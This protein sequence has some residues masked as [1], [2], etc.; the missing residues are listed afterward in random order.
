MGLAAV[1]AAAVTYSSTTAYPGSLVAVPVVGAG[2]VMAGGSAQPARGAEWLLHLRPFQLLGLVSYSLYLWH[3]P[4][5]IIAA[6]YYG[7]ASLGAGD[8][9]ALMLVALALAAGTYLVVENPVRRSRYLITRPLATGAMACCLVAA[10]LAVTT[11]GLR[12]SKP[13]AIAAVETA[14]SGST[15][16]T[17]SEAEVDAVRSDYPS[18]QSAPNTTIGNGDRL[19]LVGDST[20]CTLLPGLMAVGQDY[21]VKVFN[22]GVIGCGI[23]SGTIAPY[24]YANRNLVA[25]TKSCQSRARQAEDAAIRRGRPSIILWAS[26]EETSSIVADTGTG[27]TVLVVGTP[28]WDVVMRRRIEARVHQFVTTGAKVILVLEPPPLDSGNPSQ[29]TARDVN[30]SVMNELLRQVAAKNP[31][32]VGVVNLEELLCPS[33]PPCPGAVD[34]IAVRGDGIHYLPP[35]SVWVARWLVPQVLSAAHKLS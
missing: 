22:G 24:Y 19:L 28:R 21:G 4:I 17:P 14:A 2:L 9:A 5:L 20:A 32:H 16:P 31:G 30:Y 29:P 3:W 8:N 33:G 12:H 6:E 15:C 13:G 11:F 18:G 34:G 1:V 23:V 25:Y 35:E 10:S 27:S 7:K 26:T